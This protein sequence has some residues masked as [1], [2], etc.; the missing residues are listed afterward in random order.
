MIELIVGVSLVSILAV[1]QESEIEI[2]LLCRLIS[3]TEIEFPFLIE[4]I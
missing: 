3:L 2:A 1:L 4:C